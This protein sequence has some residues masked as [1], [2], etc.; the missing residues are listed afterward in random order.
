MCSNIFL[1]FSCV[2]L[3]VTPWTAAHQAPLS[4][5]IS[6]SLLR[7]HVLWV[8]DAI[9]CRPLLLCAVFPGIRVFST[10]LVLCTRWPKCWSFSISPSNEYLGLIS[11]WI[12]WFNLFCCLRDSQESSPALQFESISSLVL[13]LLYDPTLT[14]VYDYGKIHSFDCMDLCWQSDVS[15][16]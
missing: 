16:F 7:P 10:E 9:L 6:W 3:F 2:Q 11:F 5:T 1:L 14:S 15:V 12:D 13:S 8:G 4:F